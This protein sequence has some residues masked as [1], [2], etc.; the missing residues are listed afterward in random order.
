MTDEAKRRIKILSFWEKHGLPATLEARLCKL[1]IS[2]WAKLTADG[3]TISLT[4]DDDAW[5]EETKLDGCYVL[6]TDLS[7]IV[8]SKE[9]VHDRYKDL[10]LVERAFRESKTVY[11][12]MRP[13]YMRKP[14]PHAVIP[15]W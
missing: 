11:L 14:T 2:P 13:V 12:Q 7:S 10:A 6:K 5:E 15:W 9:V 8:A 3:R 1:R 4:K